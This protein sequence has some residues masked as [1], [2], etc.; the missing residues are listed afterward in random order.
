M[1]KKGT[2]IYSLIF[3]YAVSSSSY[4][5]LPFEKSGQPKPKLQDSKH[6]KLILPTGKE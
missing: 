4:S 2:D 6:L 3:E 5:G 1:Q